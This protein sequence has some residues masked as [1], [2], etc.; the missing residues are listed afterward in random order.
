MAELSTTALTIGE[1]A[2]RAGLRTSAIRYYEERGLLRPAERI[3]G[4]RR[5]D[6]RALERLAV[7]ELAKEAGFRLDEIEQLLAHAG[8]ERE[9]WRAMAEGKLAEV[10]LLIARAEVMRRTLRS[11]L[12]CGCLDLSECEAFAARVAA[13]VAPGPAEAADE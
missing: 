10:E 3:N 12:E 8:S 1:V 13:R 2:R 5:Y 4:I 9:H 7:I 11:S 6:E